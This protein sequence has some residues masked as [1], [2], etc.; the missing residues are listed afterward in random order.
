MY[1]STRCSS[2][3]RMNRSSG[4]MSSGAGCGHRC[5][6]NGAMDILLLPGSLPRSLQGSSG[7][8]GYPLPSVLEG[9]HRIAVIVTGNMVY[10]LEHYFETDALIV[11]AE[12]QSVCVLWNIAVADECLI[13]SSMKPSLFISLYFRSPTFTFP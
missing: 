4:R 10:T 8:G 5:F 9:E 11:G 2:D 13:G 3:G 7:S 6:R 1:S 12:C